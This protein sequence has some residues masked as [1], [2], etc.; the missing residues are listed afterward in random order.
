MTSADPHEGWD[1][2]PRWEIGSLVSRV[3]LSQSAF[4]TLVKVWRGRSGTLVEKTPHSRIGRVWILT[5]QQKE[6]KEERGR[7]IEG[8]EEKKCKLMEGG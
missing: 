2:S 6:E 1:S 4:S 8:K 5:R 7:V 3:K